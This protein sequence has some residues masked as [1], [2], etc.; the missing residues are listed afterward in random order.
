GGAY[1][2][3]CCA[4]RPPKMRTAN[5]SKTVATFVTDQIFLGIFLSVGPFYFGYALSGLRFA[6]ASLLSVPTFLNGLWA[7]PHPVFAESG[8]HTAFQ[9]IIQITL[10]LVRSAGRRIWKIGNSLQNH[11]T[12]TATRGTKITKAF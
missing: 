6:P 5:V 9:K 8:Y 10:T 11:G 4:L 7:G 1:R 2:R 3:F 12:G